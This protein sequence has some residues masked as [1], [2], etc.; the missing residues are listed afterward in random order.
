MYSQMV[1]Q[2]LRQLNVYCRVSVFHG[3][4]AMSYSVAFS[5]RVS[6]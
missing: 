5:N 2:Q 4:S 3:K 1:S 6:V